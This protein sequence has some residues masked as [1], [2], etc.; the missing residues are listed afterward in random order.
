MSQSFDPSPFF[1]PFQSDETPGGDWPNKGEIDII[2]G[3]NKGDTNQMTLH[4]NSGCRMSGQSQTGRTVQANCDVA[5]TGN[6][7]CGESSDGVTISMMMMQVFR[8]QRETLTETTSTALAVV[9][10]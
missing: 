5:A 8:T 1:V 3:V 4:T 2:E 9:L 7:G 6:S 10:T